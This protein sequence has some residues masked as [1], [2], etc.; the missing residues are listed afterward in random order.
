MLEILKPVWPAFSQQLRAR[1]LNNSGH[2]IANKNEEEKISFTQKLA[3]LFLIIS[4]FHKNWRNSIYYS[5]S[6]KRTHNFSLV[7]LVGQDSDKGIAFPVP[8][9]ADKQ[10]TMDFNYGC[11]LIKNWKYLQYNT[12]AIEII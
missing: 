7:E 6:S 9:I 10:I 8:S 5:S 11:S 4:Y 1:C 3:F 12:V 2:G